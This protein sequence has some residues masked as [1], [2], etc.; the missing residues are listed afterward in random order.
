MAPPVSYE[1]ERLILKF[2]GGGLS[3]RCIKE[4]LKTHG[5]DRSIYTINNVI[6]CKG[7]KRESRVNGQKWTYRRKSPVLTA[8]VLR[9]IKRKI[10]V[11][12]PP[13]LQNLADQIHI[14]LPTIQRAIR[15]KIIMKTKK[16]TKVHIL[17]ER[18]K[19][20]RKT[21]S[22][23]LYENHLSGTKSEFVVTLDEAM[24]KVR[25]KGRERGFYYVEIGKKMDENIPVPVNEN[26]PDQ[27]MI[28]GA[29]CEKRTFP[30]IIV[31][32]KTKMNAELYVKLVLQPLIEKHLVPYYGED[33]NKVVIHHDKATSHVAQKTADF[34][35]DMK[36]K[37]GI[38][39]LTK[40]EIPV[41]GADISPMDFFGFSF[42]KL[43]VGKSR[44]KTRLGVWKKCC[45]AWND[46]SP[47]TCYNVFQAWKRRCRA[48][49]K[50]DGDVIEHLK[51]IHKR[52]INL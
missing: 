1:E 40:E 42:I 43:T 27:F 17:T 21:N 24:M 29:M 26:F 11:E 51:N 10:K 33:I 32:K 50:Q 15:D 46:V 20:N 28:V 23:K 25:Q 16:K 13:T 8:D 47:D 45:D 22:R 31:P 37:Y 6:N 4:R 2:S 5:F 52:K 44:A 38:R 7:I 18:D 14:P 35:Q 19:N 30:L 36:S 3:V 12:N 48:V 41:K 9:T 39:C 49:S 34:F